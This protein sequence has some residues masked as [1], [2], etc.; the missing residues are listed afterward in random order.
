MNQVLRERVTHE[1]EM[2]S[3]DAIESVLKFIISLENRKIQGTPGSKLMKFAGTVSPE[4]AELMLQAVEQDCRKF[5]LAE[6]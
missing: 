3:D 5:N 2:L 1:L 4:D 6:W